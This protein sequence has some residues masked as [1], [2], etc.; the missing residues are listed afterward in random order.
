M[1]VYHV[2]LEQGSWIWLD[3]TRWDGIG[4]FVPGGSIKRGNRREE[5]RGEG[6]GLGNWAEQS[7]TTKKEEKKEDL[8]EA[9]VS[10][11]F[12]NSGGY[13]GFGFGYRLVFTSLWAT[14]Y[15]YPFLLLLLII[16]ISGSDEYNAVSES[17]VYLAKKMMLE[18][19]D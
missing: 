19:L 9:G 1:V 6:K 4:V 18:M 7:R 8:A 3:G 11:L 16:S 10:E 2:P 13:Y 12:K 5:K 14:Y 15:Y 17:I